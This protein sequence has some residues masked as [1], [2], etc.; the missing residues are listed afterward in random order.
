M[1]IDN[2]YFVGEINIPNAEKN[3][4]SIQQAINQYEKE[5]L[6]MLLGYKLYS[7]LIADCTGEG[8]VPVTQKYMD[9]V[10]GAEFTQIINGDTVTLKWEGFTNAIKQS[11][12]AYYVYYKYVE[13]EVTHLS[14]VGTILTPS[15]KGVRA[16]SENKMINAWEKMR[17]LYGVVPSS[18]RNRIQDPIKMYGF[19]YVFN[20]DGSAY[21]FLNANKA[22]YPDWYFTPQWNIN[23]FGI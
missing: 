1:F 5:I 11:L 23:I 6:I 19:D 18:I 4:T 16:S 21:N 12:V 13:R 3:T 9:L 15:N 17:L 2:T 22:D 7:L 20:Y 10:N 14:G 8:N